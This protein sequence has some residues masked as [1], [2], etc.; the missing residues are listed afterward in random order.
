MLVLINVIHD[1]VPLL[2]IFMLSFDSISR[3]ELRAVDL[4]LRDYS[5]ASL[6]PPPL[7]L[8]LTLFHSLS[9][10]LPLSLNLSLSL[11]LYL[12]FLFLFFSLFSVSNYSFYLTLFIHCVLPY[13]WFW[14]K[15]GNDIL[16][17]RYSDNYG[18]GLK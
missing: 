14:L 2:F 1:H 5:S 18:G 11:L 9:L 6:P 10:S 7:A 8:S 13:C 4:H 3:R 12:S 16:D 17:K 15:K